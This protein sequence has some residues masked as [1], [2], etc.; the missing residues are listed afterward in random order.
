MINRLKETK[1]P[2]GDRA[3]ISASAINTF[4]Q[5]PTKYL[6]EYI[7]KMKGDEIKYVET[8]EGIEFHEWGEMFYSSGENLSRDDLENSKYM[9]NNPYALNIINAQI[10]HL[11][12]CGFS[13]VFVRGVEVKFGS[14]E[15]HFIGYIDRLD[16]MED[17]NMCVVDY[18]PKDKRK[19]PTDVKRQVH[20]Y[21][22][23]LNFLIDTSSKYQE[24]FGSSHVTHALILGYK[25]SSHWFF[26]IK[27]VTTN[28]MNKQIE[29][30]I[31]TTEFH[32]KP[33]FLC[34]YCKYK[35]MC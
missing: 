18:K 21:A 12:E 26:P 2:L 29:K 13:G 10:K 16:E 34:Q 25:D 31:T 4:V 23:K 35:N 3:C 9:T 17:G 11:D 5:C 32:S 7:F 15:N 8:Q 22:N 24:L 27:K 30:M 28:A 14:K 33:G 20:F 6:W 1:I 19:Y